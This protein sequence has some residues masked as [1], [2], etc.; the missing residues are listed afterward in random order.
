MR[1]VAYREFSQFVHGRI[2][3][4]RIPLP[5]CTYTKIRTK[6]QPKGNDAFTGFQDDEWEDNEH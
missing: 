1:S 5:A 6:F 2:G 4:N 3:R